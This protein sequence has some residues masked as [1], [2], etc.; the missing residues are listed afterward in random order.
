MSTPHTQNQNM[1]ATE[2]DPPDVTIGVRLQRLREQKGLSIQEMHEETRISSTNLAAI[3]AEN[4]DQLPAD[5]FV[6]GLI[7][8]YGSYL[9]LDGAETARLFLKE[10]DQRQP[11]GRKNRFGKQANSLTPKKLA[12]P[13]H[14]SSATVAGILLLL[15]VITLT[16]FCLYTGWTPFAYF[17]DQEQQSTLPLKGDV[18]PRSENEQAAT[19]NLPKTTP[20]TSAT[21]LIQ[22]S[23]TTESANA[24]VKSSTVQQED[25]AILNNPDTLSHD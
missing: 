2:Y 3:E 8:I 15:I 7:N 17:F 6:R 9:G 19:D 10:R 12:E 4:F 23:A 16:T 14:I 1:E 11:K 20:P 18:A 24:S 5:T 13:S 22:D 25:Q 21:I